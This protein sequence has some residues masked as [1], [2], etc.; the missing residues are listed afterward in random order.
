MKRG[1]GARRAGHLNNTPHA[2]QINIV[3]VWMHCKD[4]PKARRITKW[5]RLVSTILCSSVPNT[6]S[7]SLGISYQDRETRCCNVWKFAVY[8]GAALHVGETSKRNSYSDDAT[9]ALQILHSD[10][11]TVYTPAIR[12]PTCTS[13]QM[14]TTNPSN[15]RFDHILL[16]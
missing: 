15:L 11:A 13:A 10:S 16:F 3:V 8:Q 6:L 14:P 12:N 7:N 1:E 5:N 2:N 4:K 9:T